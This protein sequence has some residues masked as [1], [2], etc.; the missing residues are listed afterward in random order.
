MKKIGLKILV[1]FAFF[2]LFPT[3][4][5]AEE[6]MDTEEETTQEVITTEEIKEQD[7]KTSYTLLIDDQANLLTE[8]EELQ[9]KED[10]KSLL[11]YG[12]IAFTSTNYNS[13]STSTF[14]RSYYHEHF[15]TESGTLF[16][17][18]MA[19]RE[20]YI[21][22]DGENY[23]YIT[24]SKAYLITDNI[25]KYA[26]NEQ[27]YLCAKK[28]FEQIKT[29]LE[30]GKIAEPMR[31]TSNI[32]LSLVVSFM[33]CFFFVTGKSKIQA[34]S[35]N[36]ILKNCDVAFAVND[37]TGTKTGTHKVYNPPSSSGGSSGGGGGGGGGGSSGG[38]GGHGF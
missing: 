20:I 17:I 32:V 27:Y 5:F 3:R 25:Y 16:V 28:A 12:N 7:E 24:N 35:G 30:G 11:A 23:R 29:V 21:F 34:A 31:H 19:N 13:S 10:M 26:T 18:D 33:I 2:L 9:L 38:G 15:D 22:S 6:V 36:S 1:I 14:A 8:E 37:I 4:I